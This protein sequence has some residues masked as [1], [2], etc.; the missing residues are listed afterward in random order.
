ML[1]Q[2]P[3]TR[4]TPIIALSAK[5]LKYEIEAGMKAGFT[6]YLTKPVH[7]NELLS[8]VEKYCTASFTFQ[9]IAHNAR[10]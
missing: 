2:L 3:E 6:S 1:Q 10:G 9:K 8:T 4:H 5:V 7:S